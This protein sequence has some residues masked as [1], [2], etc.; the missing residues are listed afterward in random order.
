MSVGKVER[1]GVFGFACSIVTVVRLSL[2]SNAQTSE[3]QFPVD[4]GMGDRFSRRW[5]S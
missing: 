3:S 4:D 5:I 1:D 2:L